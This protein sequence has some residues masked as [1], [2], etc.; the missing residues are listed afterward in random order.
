[1]ATNQEGQQATA[2]TAGS[3][4]LVFNGDFLS[5]FAAS[6]VTSG[7]Y[8]ERLLTWI[9]AKLLASYTSLPAAQQAYAESEGFNNWSS[10]GAFTP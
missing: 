6:A 7:T 8:N 9:N 1:M 4:A 5:M 2:R 3:S 10:M